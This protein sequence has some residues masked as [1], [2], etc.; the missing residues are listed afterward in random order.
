M[1]LHSSLWSADDWATRGGLVKTDWTKAPFIASYRN[2]NANACIWSSG[3]SSCTS[4]STKGE[5]LSQEMDLASKQKLKMV[6][7]KFMIYN[8]CT[9]TK[10]FPQG[11]PKECSRVSEEIRK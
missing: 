2:F 1:R 4:P 8:Y 11:F 3:T 6:Q 7:E 5:W 10:R 9:D